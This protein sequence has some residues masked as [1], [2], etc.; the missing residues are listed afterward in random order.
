[1]ANGMKDL[2]KFAY[3]DIAMEKASIDTLGYV[4]QLQHVKTMWNIINHV[5]DIN[6]IDN[7][8]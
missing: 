1:M 4:H 6:S 3:S 5:F 2:I 7:S 8:L